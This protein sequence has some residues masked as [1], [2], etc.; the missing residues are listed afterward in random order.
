MTFTDFGVTSSNTEGYYK[1]WWGWIVNQFP[2]QSASILIGTTHPSS[3]F[4]SIG[5]LYGTHNTE[6]DMKNGR[7][8]YCCLFSMAFGSIARSCGYNDGSWFMHDWNHN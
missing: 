5:Y 4:F 8:R 7:P 3:K 1:A 2:N 6:Y